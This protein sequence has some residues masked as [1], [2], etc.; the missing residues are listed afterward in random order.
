[1]KLG[2]GGELVA[3]ALDGAFE[4]RGQNE[5]GA[6]ARQIHVGAGNRKPGAR[7]LRRRI[8]GDDFFPEGARGGVV[9]GFQGH[10]GQGIERLV[11][12]T[13]GQCA[14]GEFEQSLRVALAHG[15]LKKR[16][17]L[18]VDAV[19]VELEGFGRERGKLKLAVVAHAHV[20][21]V[22]HR[23]QLLARGVHDA[24]QRIDGFGP[25]AAG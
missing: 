17:G 16:L 23:H 18:G 10:L 4:N 15:L 3:G 14:I 12:P 8:V 19:A 11:S 25:L 5:A 9:A 2:Q 6:D 13:A 20:A 1:M 21:A 24:E 7:R 22:G